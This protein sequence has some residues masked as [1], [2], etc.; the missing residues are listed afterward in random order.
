[1]SNR[2]S[3]NVPANVG[4]ADRPC[5]SG[6]A[7]SGTKLALLI[8]F[9]R[10]T[11]LVKE[12]LPVGH[13][14]ITKRCGSMC[15]GQQSGSSRSWA[16]NGSRPLFEGRDDDV[17]QPLSKGPMTV[18]ID[19]GYVRAAHKEGCFEV[20]AGRSVVAFRRAEGEEV[21]SAKC[22]GFVQTFDKKPRRR[23]SAPA[24]TSSFPVAAHA[25]GKPTMSA[26]AP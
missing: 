20:I 23:L 14:P 6:V 9:A 2:G 1:M 15:R 5:Q 11:D 3:Q 22:L 10:V 24:S 4:L 21:P 8:P 7:L 19:G 12:V 18:G 16:K 13:P 25:P 26:E 17:E